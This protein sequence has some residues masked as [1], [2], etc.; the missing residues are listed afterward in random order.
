MQRNKARRLL[1]IFMKKHKEELK[2]VPPE[3]AHIKI[4]DLIAII[5]KVNDLIERLS[6]PVHRDGAITMKKEDV[7]RLS[8]S[9]LMA[10]CE[11]V[12]A[13]RPHG[14]AITPKWP[15]IQ[16]VVIARRIPVGVAGAS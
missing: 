1:V 9:A 8:N 5:N 4:A 12:G 3:V 11:E 6:V 15:S 16:Q 13:T 7:K 10:V 2:Y 14:S